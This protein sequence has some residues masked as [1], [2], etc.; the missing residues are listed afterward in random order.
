M[1]RTTP[2]T[3]KQP[4]PIRDAKG[5]YVKGRS[6]NPTV[7]ALEQRITALEGGAGTACFAT[8]IHDQRS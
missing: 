3:P 6:G 2:K 8:G 4:K 1:T 7:V 5:R